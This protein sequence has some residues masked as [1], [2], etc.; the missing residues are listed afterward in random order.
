MGFAGLNHASMYCIALALPED[1]IAS[2]SL[3]GVRETK[4]Q[5]DG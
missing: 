1:K 2:I 3:V 4:G 5:S